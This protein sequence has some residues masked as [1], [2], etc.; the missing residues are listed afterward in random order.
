MRFLAKT[1]TIYIVRKTLNHDFRGR[2]EKETEASFCIQGFSSRPGYSEVLH[3]V[4]PSE[5]IST[6][7]MVQTDFI[8]LVSDIPVLHEPV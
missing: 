8:S 6:S 7:L 2:G 4:V 1:A 5:G 3:I